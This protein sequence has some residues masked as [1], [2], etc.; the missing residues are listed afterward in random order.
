MPQIHG[1]I[2]PHPLAILPHA[3]NKNIIT[4]YE[5]LIL[6]YLDLSL[7][8][9]QFK[10]DVIVVI[11]PRGVIYLDQIGI[12]IPTDNKYIANLSEINQP[13]LNYEFDR[14][15]TNQLIKIAETKAFPFIRTAESK[16]DR[17]AI[18]PLFY[19]TRALTKKPE[20]V[21]IN[22]SYLSPEKHFEFGKLIAE[23]Y[24]KT[25]KKV[26]IIAAAD[27]ST[28][29]KQKLDQELLNDLSENNYERITLYDTFELDE[30]GEAGIRPIATL[31]GAINEQHLH[32]QNPTYIRPEQTGYLLISTL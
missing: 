9:E 16:L 10:P 7:K 28:G 20:L 5:Q 13:D 29:K 8:V 6:G 27:L 24:E 11:S 19:L 32:W 3:A 2:A 4:Q 31:L 21:S 26:L 14:I 12:V 15:E 30:T 25:N 17:G 23:T 1:I 18:V 22:S